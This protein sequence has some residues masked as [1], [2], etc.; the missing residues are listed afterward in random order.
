MATFD[1]QIAPRRRPDHAFA[2]GELRPRRVPRD[3]YV[4]ADGHAWR[5]PSEYVG[6]PV[7]IQRT[8]A[9]GLRGLRGATVLVEHRPPAFTL[10]G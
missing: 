8:R 5:V 3:G 7:T 1:V 2:F 4:R 6:Q 9:G 10:R